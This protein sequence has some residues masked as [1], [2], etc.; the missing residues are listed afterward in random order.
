MRRRFT[1]S[2]VLICGI[3]LCAGCGWLMGIGGYPPEA[4]RTAPPP[5]ISEAL[6]VGSMAPAFELQAHDGT[7]VVLDTVLADK[8]VLLVFYRGD[9]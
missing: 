5:G 2:G 1:R 7:K 3:V 6:T 9:W 8:P 4:M